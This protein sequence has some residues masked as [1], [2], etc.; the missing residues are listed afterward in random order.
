MKRLD[1][2]LLAGILLMTA[3]PVVGAEDCYV[4][5]GGQI[6]CSES[7]PTTVPASIDSTSCT[8]TPGDGTNLPEC[9]TPDDNECYP[10]GT[11]AGKCDS[12]WLWKAGWEIA[13]FND[14]RLTR[15][16]VNEAWRFLLPPPVEGLT[17]LAPGCYQS[18]DFSFDLQYFGPINTARNYISWDSS[19]G[20]CSG[21]IVYED[22]IIYATS[23]SEALDLC[24]MVW[25]DPFI[26]VYE[27]Y[28]SYAG[29]P[30]NYW[31]C[32]ID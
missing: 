9:G 8:L 4:D 28:Q 12:D 5:A 13:R 27:L 14:G 19:D 3:L 30:A 6:V 15:E 31:D 26:D 21:N 18:F 17:G 7:S 16:Q 2:I 10:G 1:L 22:A 11:M 20:S 25:S 23:L 29:I 32:Y 24:E